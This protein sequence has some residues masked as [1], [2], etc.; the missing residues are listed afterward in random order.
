[1][2]IDRRQC[3]F[4][5]DEKITLSYRLERPA[6][7]WVWVRCLDSSARWAVVEA[8]NQSPGM[9]V[10]D[11]DGTIP[12]I[13]KAPEGVY[14][15]EFDLEIGDSKMHFSPL[16]VPYL[17][18]QPLADMEVSSEGKITYTLRD[19]SLV[20]IRTGIRKGPLYRT[21][22]NWE[23]RFPGPVIEHWGGSDETGQF[24]LLGRRDMF[25]IGDAILLPSEAFI[26]GTG[27]KSDCRDALSPDD[28]KN[29]YPRKD[30]LVDVELMN[31]Q[32][33]T[34]AG[35][36]IVSDEALLRLNLDDAYFVYALTKRF[37]WI[38]FLDDKFHAEVE[39]GYTPYNWLLDVS[40]MEPGEHT[41]TV[42]GSVLSGE[43]GAASIR[44]YVPERKD[45][46]E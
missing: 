5:K 18:K 10:V 28:T 17:R 4:E 13:G 6:R 7:V 15:F 14:I 30:V 19:L 1:V 40:A 16:D 31:S 39:S 32:G 38:V 8:E 37:E 25:V 26:V 27:L 41:I 34:E 20:L 42:N 45:A 2:Q 9:H 23:P 43:M 29:R 46:E 12:E 36:P 35:V 21:I 33:N 11:W 24:R 3:D 44:I 22:V